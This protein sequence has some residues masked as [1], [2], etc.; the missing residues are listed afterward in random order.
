M[1][2][3]AFWETDVMFFLLSETYLYQNCICCLCKSEKMQSREFDYF[4]GEDQQLRLSC[5]YNLSKELVF[6]SPGFYEE[7][8]DIGNWVLISEQLIAVLMKFSKNNLFVKDC[9]HLW[10][11]QVT[12]GLC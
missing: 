1:S 5:H 6:S 8:D 12:F 2:S 11:L 3:I 10:H 7:I 4:V 9:T